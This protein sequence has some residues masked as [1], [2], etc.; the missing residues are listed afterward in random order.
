[1]LLWEDNK[2]LLKY[3]HMRYKA[4]DIIHA[5]LVSHFLPLLYSKALFAIHL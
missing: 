2:Q 4:E 3:I 5:S 1:M